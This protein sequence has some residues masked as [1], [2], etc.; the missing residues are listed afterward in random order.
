MD[1]KIATDTLT[2]FEHGRIETECPIDGDFLL[3]DYCP[4]IA[5]VLKCALSPSVLSRRRSGDTLLVEGQSAVR[6]LYLDEDRRC[7][8]TYECMIPFTCSLPMSDNG[9]ALP[10]VHMRVNYLNCRAVS[11]RRIDIHGALTAYHD[12]GKK[13]AVHV[14]S[15]IE[16]EGVHSRCQTVQCS[17]PGC[18]AEKI[19]S[20][21]EVVGVGGAKPPAQ[22][23]VRT[24]IVP[25]VASVKPLNDKVIVKG[26][27]K[28]ITLYAVNVEEG[29]V[30]RVAH[31]FPFSQIVEMQGAHEHMQC[32][33]QVDTVSDSVHITP[34][35]SGQGTLFTVSLKLCVRVDAK[36]ECRKDV[37]TDAYTVR[38]PANVETVRFTAEALAFTEQNTTSIK[39]VLDLPSDTMREIVDLWCEV[40]SVTTRKIDD[41]TYADGRLQIC[42]PVRDADGCIAY[43]EHMS[44]FTL[45]F[46]RPCDRM[47]VGVRLCD[48]TYAVVGG[49]IE[50]H[51][52]LA[53][54][55]EGYSKTE[56]T[57]LQQF[58]LQSEP[59]PVERAALRLCR[60][61]KGASV[62]EIAKSFHTDVQAIM[63]ENAICEECVPQDCM[64]LVPLV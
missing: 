39:E 64:L 53:T 1:L 56:H 6:L 46:D 63:E 35:Q 58:E 31:E 16:G 36:E 21:S 2:I 37:L 8:R 27:V 62:W 33:A 9:D 45:Q 29:S 47:N 59:Y 44:D 14:V 60:V 17:L 20:I 55:C 42:M 41:C 25:M 3:P 40:V 30:C 4:D 48:V 61:Q 11:P 23:I 24:E 38:Y 51:M 54:Q 32:M 28:V 13:Q 34:D 50:M 7:L 22:T 19:F 5:A 57:A 43:Y 52:E 49:K 10:Y 12:G 15:A 18:N 26:S